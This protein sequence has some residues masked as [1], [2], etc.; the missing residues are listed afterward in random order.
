MLTTDE[1]CDKLVHIL[2]TELLIEALQITPDELLERF[3]DKVELHWDKL[4]EV[5]DDDGYEI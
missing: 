3:A 1:L 2:D 5:I 4:I